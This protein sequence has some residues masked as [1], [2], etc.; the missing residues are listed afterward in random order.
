MVDHGF[1]HKFLEQHS[2]VNNIASIIHSN[3]MLYEV[4]ASEKLNGMTSARM[5]GLDKG[6][7]KLSTI[8]CVYYDNM[9]LKC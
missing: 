6:V 5:N 9:T 3:I 4:L 1:F 7:K 8:K 2:S